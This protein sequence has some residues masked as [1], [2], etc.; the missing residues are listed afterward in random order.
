MRNLNTP[1]LQQKAAF[2]PGRPVLQLLQQFAGH[3]DGAAEFNGETPSGDAVI[4]YYQ[5]RRHI[6]GDLKIEV[7]DANGKLI[8]TIPSSKRRGLSRVTWS[9]RLPP[10]PVPNAA[11]A[12]NAGTFGPRLLPGTYTVRLSKDGEVLTTQID[13]KADPRWNA[14]AGDRKA[15]FDLSLKLCD[16]FADMTYAVAKINGVREGLVQRAAALPSGE[17]LRPR[18]EKAADDLDTLRKRIVATK[19]GGMLTGEERLRENLDE[20]Y[21]GVVYYE[22][23]PTAAQTE[24]ADAIARELADTVRDFDA[25]TAKELPAINAALGKNPVKVLTR[26]EWQKSRSAAAGGAVAAGRMEGRFERD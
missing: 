21:F 22:G 11:T 7:L 20:L 15:Q 26:E 1:L 9:M 16:I 8:E 19:E 6:F 4:T 5:R 12:A 13:V 10:P 14:T 25:W 23:R 18:L 17:R 3:P 24:R 2:L